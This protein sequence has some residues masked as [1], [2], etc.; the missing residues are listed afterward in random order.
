MT[1]QLSRFALYNYRGEPKKHFIVERTELAAD[2]LE[3]APEVTHHIFVVDRSGSM[4]Y[5]MAAL[6][7]MLE[8]LLTLEEYRNAEMRATLISYSSM[9]DYTVHFSRKTV[10]Q[11]MAP[12]SAEVEQIRQL[13]VTGLTCISQ[14][15][16]AA[17]EFIEDGETTAISL[18]SDGYANDRSPTSERREIDRICAELAKRPSVFV[19]TI[20][21]S[22]Y[23]DFKLLAAIAN[24]MSGKCVQAGTVKEV[25]DALND[26]T[27]L[28]AGR[29]APSI[30]VGLEDYT[31]QVFVSRSAERVNGAGSDM[32]IRGLKPEDDKA[33]Y[34]FIEVGEARYLDSVAPVCGNAASLEPVYAFAMAKL[35][36]GQ[37]NTSKF[38]LMATRNMTLTR[39][40]YRA[41]TAPALAAMYLD[42]QT[43]IMTDI[44]WPMLPHYGLG[45]D[46][47]PLLTLLGFLGKHA[48]DLTVNL[49]DL[50][51]HYN[52]RG[53]KKVPGRRDE[54]GAVVAPAV[55]SQIVGDKTFADI[56]S[57][58]LNNNT[59]NINMLCVR[60]IELVKDD[61]VIDEVAGIRFTG[62]DQLKAY[63]NYTIV[64]DGELNLP[65]LR[66][67][68]RHKA[69]FR[70]LVKWGLIDSTYDVYEFYDLDLS[71]LPLVDFEQPF[72]PTSLDGTFDKL[73]RSKVLISMVSAL[74]T[75]KSDRFTNEQLVELDEHHISGSL[76]FTPPVTTPYASLNDALGAGIVDSRVS[77]KID[78]GNTKILRRTQLHSGNAMCKRFY[79]ADGTKNPKLVA[80][81]DTKVWTHKTLSSRTKIT[82][83]DNLM[84]PIFDDFFGL[85]DTGAFATLLAEVGVDGDDIA[86]FEKARADLGTVD[87]DDLVEMFTRVRRQAECYSEDVFD[88]SVRPLVFYIGA[89]G[90]LPDE[91]DT[92]ALTAEAIKN[93]HPDLKIGSKEKEGTFFLIDETVL[94]VFADNV[95]FTV[96][97]KPAEAVSA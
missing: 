84:K 68:I 86:L 5:D 51:L 71:E 7:T 81:W 67:Q 94:S 39:R 54:T 53:L 80:W 20:A 63:N 69:A 57:F 46:K 45:L 17:D 82:P 62:D 88:T 56:G 29:M 61:E 47:V 91:L 36:E 74:L 92:P 34:R 15:L 90:L 65:T 4:Y 52:R 97:R 96:D 64:S 19:N 8:K 3:V 85:A 35:A 28:L 95:H 78:I 50:Y 30:S 27:A 25:Y 14:A 32:V 60:P 12:G 43:A 48:S 76:Y 89:T 58:D 44:V 38:A 16:Q 24:A 79:L 41:L 75:D 66:L 23:S 72:D 13:R 6:R 70:Q 40:H 31:Y 2:E 9:G 59:A 73:A 93:K 11:I 77:Y 22:S 37:L 55:E 87:P 21:Y 26:T 33:V 18:H 1:A 10:A 83:I 42:V 49:Q